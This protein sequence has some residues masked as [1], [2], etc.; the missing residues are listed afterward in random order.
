M[1]LRNGNVE[2][3]LP[4]SNLAHFLMSQH[5]MYKSP[6]VM[7]FFCAV[8]K[9]LANSSNPQFT[10]FYKQNPDGSHNLSVRD[11]LCSRYPTTIVDVDQRD[12]TQS[13]SAVDH[14]RLSHEALMEELEEL[15]QGREGNSI[16]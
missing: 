4:P 6:V 11:L 7:K 16:G 13:S 9:L 2:L 10:L 5:I 15:Y 8:P 3:E 14:W 1:T 12:V